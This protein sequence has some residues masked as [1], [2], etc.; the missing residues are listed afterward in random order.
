MSGVSIDQLK[1]NGVLMIDETLYR[2][3]GDYTSVD[4]IN[5]YEFEAIQNKGDTFMLSETDLETN[6]EQ[7]D[8]W[9]VVLL[10]K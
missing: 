5:D 3:A 8:S 9:K 10:G 2:L 6:I 7:K 4:T 1:E